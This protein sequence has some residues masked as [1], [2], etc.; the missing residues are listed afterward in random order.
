[1]IIIVFYLSGFAL[2]PA[3]SNQLSLGEKRKLVHEVIEF[4]EDAP[5]ILSSL[6]RREL[7]EIICAEMGKE[8]KYTGLTKPRMIQHLLDIVSKKKSTDKN[9]VGFKKQRKQESPGQIGRDS[10]EIIEK[11]ETLICENLACR[12]IM[13]GEDMFC[14]RC[15]CCICYEFDDN[16]DPS[17]WLT[18]DLDSP[19]EGESCGIS[20]H[21]KCAAAHKRAGILKSGTPGKLD[22]GFYC[23]SCG[24]VNGLMR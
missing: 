24:K 10:R 17:L 18:C 2:D 22:G 9:E 13:K 6:T 16:K 21:L 4:S 1:M 14:K 12:A 23:V 20:C 8:R 3:K 7:L 15:S 5:K 19:S 11:K